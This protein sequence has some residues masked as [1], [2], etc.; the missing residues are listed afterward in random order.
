MP[1]TKHHSGAGWVPLAVIAWLTFIVG[2][3]VLLSIQVIERDGVTF[4]EYAKGLESSPYSTMM[5]QFQ[6]PGYPAIIWLSHRT[7][8]V[9]GAGESQMLWVHSAQAAAL[10]FRVASVVML[11]FVG[12]R[13]VGK[14]AA[15]LGALLLAVLPSM[16]EYGSDALS[17]WP[18][19]FF[20]ATAMLMMLR[21]AD[22]R[23]SWM[24]GLV[25]L[26][27]GLGYLVRPECAI[28]AAIGGLWAAYQAI[29]AKTWTRASAITSGILLVVC[30]AIPSVPYMAAKGALFP[31]KH[32]GEF[33]V[34]SAEDSPSAERPHIAGVIDVGTG[35]KFLR[36]FAKLFNR[37][38]ELL[39][40][41]FLL[42]MLIGGVLWFRSPQDGWPAR[43][44]VGCL[45]AIG[46]AIA[47]WLFVSHGYI[48]RRHILEIMVIAVFFVPGGL[49]A[50]SG[51][52]A[53]NNPR[54]AN[55]WT[56]ILLL[57][58]V[59]FSLVRLWGLNDNDK[60]G[61]IAAGAWLKANTSPQ[62][63]VACSDVR[64][65]FYG[66]RRYVRIYDTAVLPEADY[67]ALANRTVTEL[68]V[69]VSHDAVFRYEGKSP[70]E[71]D[72]IIFG[73]AGEVSR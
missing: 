16:A 6:H 73:R 27:S 52:C 17:D 2:L 38:G 1:A 19:L 56:S 21:S 18:S 37:M 41:Y 29:T 24:F 63:V 25:G 32:V 31:K 9:L 43:F 12:V 55:V 40:W 15:F 67:Y 7:A 34:Y 64:I 57:V 22:Q 3:Y 69:G 13:L 5:S 36:G 61:Y 46:V 48:S 35:L 23:S 20:F 65:A 42:P 66:E 45:L 11:Y 47:L 44:V 58:G 62:S 39:N 50:I 8:R 72:V 10:V 51:W 53:P 59:A 33:A 14:R 26:A 28:A 49:V 71:I 4:I 30:F 68:P 54:S 60:S 70:K